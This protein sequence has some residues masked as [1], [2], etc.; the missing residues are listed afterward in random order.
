MTPPAIPRDLSPSTRRLVVAGLAAAFAALAGASTVSAQT[1]KVRNAAPGATI[2]VM[3]NTELV[4]TTA[5]DGRGA[6]DIP[7]PG[8]RPEMDALVYVDQCSARRR[9]IIARQGVLPPPHEAACVRQEIR[10]VFVVRPAS[11]LVVDVGQDAPTLLLRQRAF[12]PDAPPRTWA[13]A[14]TGLVLSGGAGLTFLGN[15]SLF[16]CGTV[17]DCKGDDADLGYSASAV[18][19]FTPNVAAEVGVMRP[20]DMTAEGS[21]SGYRFTSALDSRLVI[22]GGRVGVPAGPVRFFGKAAADYHRATLLTTQ[23]IDERTIT[24]NGVPETIPGGTQ[25]LALRTQGW[26][27]LAGGGVEVW[28]TRHFSVNAEFGRA[29]IKGD[30]IEEVEGGI[31]DR[32]FYL[33]VGASVRI[34]R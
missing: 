14:P 3:V 26:G 25:Q 24:V 22:V 33:F 5:A 29:T 19:W 4:A 7:L 31:D 23:T 12:D 17:T 6:A 16:A 15:A 10:G 2:E 21:G 8:E 27:W 13:Q 28:L 32:A 11:T 1:V 20:G 30:P 34:G 18:Y 9:V